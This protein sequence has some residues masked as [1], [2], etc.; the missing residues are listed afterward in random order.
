MP[1]VGATGVREYGRGAGGSATRPAWLGPAGSKYRT[2]V[3]YANLKGNCTNKLDATLLEA[4]RAQC[5]LVVL[6]QTGLGHKNTQTINKHRVASTH[7]DNWKLQF[8]LPAR[9]HEQQEGVIVCSRG[10]WSATQVEN[11]IPGRLVMVRGGRT[12]AVIRLQLSSSRA[13]RTRALNTLIRH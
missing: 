7:R 10:G 1:A 6:S 4:Q 9:K 13:S 3:R 2:E 12:Q 11:I 8:A 5:C